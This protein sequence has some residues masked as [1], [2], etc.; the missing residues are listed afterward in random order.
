M[1]RLRYDPESDVLMIVVSTLASFRM[2][3]KWGT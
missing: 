3:R 2:L 1:Y